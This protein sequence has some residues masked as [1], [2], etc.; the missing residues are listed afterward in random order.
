MPAISDFLK[1]SG[2]N[3]IIKDKKLSFDW[4]KAYSFVA[5][6][7][8]KVK[9]LKT[10]SRLNFGQKEN[11]ADTGCSLVEMAGVSQSEAPAGLKN[12][13]CIIWRS[14]LNKVLTCSD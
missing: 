2:L 8:R 10:V 14:T 12:E 4:A 6:G 13:I 7:N 1:K 3:H 11:C 9:K 5:A